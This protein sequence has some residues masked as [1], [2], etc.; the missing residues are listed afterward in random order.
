MIRPK[1]NYNFYLVHDIL[2]DIGICLPT[3]LYHFTHIWTKLL[4]QCTQCQFLS[5]DVYFAG[6]F[7][8]FFEARK[9]PRKIY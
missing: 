1:R 8:Q 3:L 9:M 5:S 7:T 6:A 4:T 2:G